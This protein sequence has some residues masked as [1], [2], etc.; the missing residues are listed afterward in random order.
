MFGNQWRFPLPDMRR[1]IEAFA[2]EGGRVVVIDPRCNETAEV[3]GEHVAIKPGGEYL[4][5]SEH[6]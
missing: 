3:A 2:P 1:R 4:P 5:G 6:Q